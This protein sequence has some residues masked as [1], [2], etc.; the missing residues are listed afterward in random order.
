MAI[1]DRLQAE[2]EKH[3]RL[4]EE[5]ECSIY[6]VDPAGVT[7][8]VNGAFMKL[9]GVEK[10]EELVGKR[11]LPERFWA[12]PARGL[13]LW[14]HREAPESEVPGSASGG[15]S[16]SRSPSGRG[17]PPARSGAALPTFG[18]LWGRSEA[19]RSSVAGEVSGAP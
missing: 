8:Y 7:T 4:L 15:G 5:S 18:S 13:D 3:T 11:F 2:Q 14:T 6:T 12:D 16:G 19:M 17:T 10:C 9:L 1:K